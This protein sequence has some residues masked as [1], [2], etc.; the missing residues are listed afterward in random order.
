VEDRI[1]VL[2]WHLADRWGRVRPEGVTVPVR[3]THEMLGKLVGARRPSV[4]TAV[5]ELIQREQIA[6]ADDG[7]WLLLG[8]PPGEVGGDGEEAAAASRSS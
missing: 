8:P 7:G 1:L 3:L 2:L 4:T 5:N 6:R